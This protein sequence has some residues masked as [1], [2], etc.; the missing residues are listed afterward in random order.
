M[1][2]HLSQSKRVSGLMTCEPS[3]TAAGALPPSPGSP[4]G[5]SL[6]YQPRTQSQAR[7]NYSSAELVQPVIPSDG[8]ALTKSICAE[9]LL[10]SAV[11]LGFAPCQWDLPAHPRYWS[12][13][14]SCCVREASLN[15]GA[16]EQP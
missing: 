5:V 9:G 7:H 10:S 16:T 12:C 2:E 13:V 4:Q 8:H 15:A 6:E 14:C 3:Q 11:G 1:L